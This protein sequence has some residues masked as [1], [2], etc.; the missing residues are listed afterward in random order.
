MPEIRHG[1]IATARCTVGEMFDGFYNIAP[2]KEAITSLPS[3][4][5][6]MG[7]LWIPVLSCLLRNTGSSRK[8]S[9]KP[10]LSEQRFLRRL[11]VHTS[12]TFANQYPAQHEPSSTDIPKA[13][14]EVPLNMPDET[15]P[16]LPYS[17]IFDPRAWDELIEA[18]Y[19]TSEV[20]GAA[21]CVPLSADRE[22]GGA[23]TKDVVPNAPLSV[24]LPSTFEA[25][26]R[27]STGKIDDAKHVETI[28]PVIQ[29][30]V[31]SV[32]NIHS[33]V[34]RS[35][36]T[37]S[38]ETDKSEPSVNDA[39]F[40]GDNKTNY[41]NRV[42]KRPSDKESSASPGADGAAH[43]LG[44]HTM[45]VGLPSLRP[46][47][48]KPASSHFPSGALS[49]DPTLNEAD[50]FSDH[51]HYAALDNKMQPPRQEP[52]PNMVIKLLEATV[53][54]IICSEVITYYPESSKLDHTIQTW[55][56]LWKGKL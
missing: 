40:S 7:T 12:N 37:I 39:A 1:V 42:E 56:E 32:V 30:S 43:R 38:A 2:Q 15:E 14:A 31:S 36:L 24:N 41:P 16:I 49:P 5:Y 27:L 26:M 18:A 6:K 17:D 3:G 19:D 29:D 11:G 22:S 13:P 25:K 54:K 20:Q 34:F 21:W 8:P 55:H 53:K 33:G 46:Y 28:T 50:M 44:R 47:D 23:N 51:H 52:R 9:L 10:S 35:S 4:N 45:T 48:M